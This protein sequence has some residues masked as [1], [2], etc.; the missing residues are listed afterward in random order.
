MADIGENAVNLVNSYPD[1]SPEKTSLRQQ[2]SQSMFLE[3]FSMLTIE[4]SSLVMRL[5]FTLGRTQIYHTQNLSG[6]EAKSMRL[7]FLIFGNII[8]MKLPAVR[9]DKLSHRMILLKKFFGT[10]EPMSGI[11]QILPSVLSHS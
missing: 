4:T 8:A 6:R 2:F 7:L 10:I 1:T 3:Y 11:T 5:V 9:R